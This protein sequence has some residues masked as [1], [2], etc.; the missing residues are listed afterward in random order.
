MDSFKPV[1]EAPVPEKAAGA[2]VDSE[3]PVLELEGPEEAA[4]LGARKLENDALVADEAAIVP[5][6]VKDGVAPDVT[7]KGVNPRAE[8][9]AAVEAGVEALVVLVTVGNSGEE[10]VP[11]L[12]A[13]GFV[14]E[15]AAPVPKEK[16]DPLDEDIGTE[17][18]TTVIEA[19]LS[20]A[21]EKQIVEKSVNMWLE[22]LQDLAYDL[23]DLLDE[24]ATEA[25]RRKPMAQPTQA[26]NRSMLR[27][28]IP[29]CC[30]TNV[31]SRAVKFDFNISSK[32]DKITERI[33]D[34]LTKKNELN[35]MNNHVVGTRLRRTGDERSPTTSLV[36][37]YSGF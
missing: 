7:P 19:V 31:T 3:K 25:L 29:P 33:E 6:A 8:A 5:V 17:A 4:V 24:L 11:K 20:Y 36:D 14:V 12:T 30:S 10:T 9:E 2:I 23:D 1:V 26:S 27:K 13:A 34:L 32:I 35:W 15:T 22:Q 37:E 18:D 16:L 21:E 28:L